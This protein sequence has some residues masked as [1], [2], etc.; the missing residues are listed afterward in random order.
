ME[1]QGTTVHLT[2][3]T[4]YPMHFSFNTLDFPQVHTRTGMDRE[5]TRDWCMNVN[6]GRG[7]VHGTCVGLFQ[8]PVRPQL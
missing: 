8:Q 7:G 3:T 6:H 1:N 5:T 4:A 2:L